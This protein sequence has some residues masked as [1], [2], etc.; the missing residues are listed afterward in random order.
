MKLEIRFTKPVIESLAAAGFG[1]RSYFSD[2]R[3]KSLHLRLS[4]T[5]RGAKSWVVQRRIDGRVVRV[6]LGR[7]PDLTPENAIKAAERLG[8]QI[9]SGENPR[10]ERR[11]KASEHLTLSDALDLMLKIRSLK[12]NTKTTYSNIVSGALGDWAEKPL[13]DITPDQVATRHA[14]LIRESGGPYANSAMRTLRSIWNFT[15]SQYEDAR[16]NSLLPPNPVARLSRAKAWV[17]VTRRKTYIEGHQL[18]AWFKAV[19]TLRSEPWGTS[20]Q[21]VGDYLVFLLMTGL[22]RTEAATLTWDNVDLAAK[23]IRLVDTKNHNDHVLPLSD[24]LLQLLVERKAQC[25]AGK[26]GQQKGAKSYVFPSESS[27]GFLGEP[28]AHV[29]FV[30]RESGVSFMLHDLRRTFSTVAESL[31]LSHYALKR[32]LN[33]RMT[34]DVTAGYIGS[35]VDRLRKPMQEITDAFLKAGKVQKGGKASLAGTS[36]S[37]AKK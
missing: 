4:V 2:S 31:D 26:G 13:L 20:A 7:Y 16:G 14:K 24:F 25:V 27:T 30:K 11:A 6:T 9:A 5:D 32:L 37:R 33:H 8:G 21:T 23:L 1:T 36:R 22:R 12:T 29:D 3:Y 34:G 18:Q 17:R 28:R 19:Q 10:A 15:A 35:N